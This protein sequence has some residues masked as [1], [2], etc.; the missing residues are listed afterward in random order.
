MRWI[1]E[2]AYCCGGNEGYAI[3]NPEISA[4]IGKKVIEEAEK[5]DA[6]VLVTSCPLCKELLSKNANGKNIEV[7]ELSELITKIL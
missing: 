7:Y 6:E 5:V 3:V 4:R 2:K 1:K